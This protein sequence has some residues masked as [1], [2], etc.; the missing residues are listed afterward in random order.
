MSRTPGVQSHCG[1]GASSRRQQGTYLRG[2]SL[3]GSGGAAVSLHPFPLATDCVL[4]ECLGEP[5][6]PGASSDL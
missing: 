4:L 2:G 5:W 6:L 3:V 1:G